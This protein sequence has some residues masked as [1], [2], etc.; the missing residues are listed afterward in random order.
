RRLRGEIDVAEVG[1]PGDPALAVEEHV[2]EVQVAVADLGAQQWPAWGDAL[3]EAVEDVLDESAPRGVRDRLDVLAEV[4]RVPHV[5]EQ[6]SSCRRVEIAA[7]G[8]VQ[9]RVR[10]SVGEER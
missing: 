3:V 2:V 6:L 5:P 10:P 7:E 4:G 1:D 9:A 8:E